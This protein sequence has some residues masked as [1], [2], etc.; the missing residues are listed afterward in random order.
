MTEYDNSRLI[1]FGMAYCIRTIFS[2]HFVII[3]LP[4]LN[5]VRNPHLFPAFHSKKSSLETLENKMI[6][7][8]YGYEFIFSGDEKSFR[9]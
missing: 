2:S 7:Y 3:M 4:L 8:G 1:K 6:Y 5:K 9:G